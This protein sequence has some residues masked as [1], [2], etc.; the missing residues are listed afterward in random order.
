MTHLRNEF[1]GL[2]SYF[3]S[4]SLRL[5]AITCAMPA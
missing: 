5:H 4:L 2:V 3:L 1:L